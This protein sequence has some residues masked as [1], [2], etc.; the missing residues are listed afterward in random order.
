MLA[1]PS[2][3]PQASAASAARAGEQAAVDVDL[4]A[5]DVARLVAGQHHG[6]GRHFVGQA[7]AAQR[8]V[9][10]QR[11]HRGFALRAAAQHRLPH[12]GQ[13][14]RRVQA[15]AADV[16]ALRRAVQ[17]HRLGVVAH[18]G[19]A[20]RV[21]RR[22]RDADDARAR[23]D[24]DDGAAAAA[25]HRA[26]AVLAAQEHAVEVGAVHGLPVLQAGAFRVVGVARRLQAG[27]AGVVDEHV[28]TA[29]AVQQ[30]RHRAHPGHLLAHVQPHPV[31]AQAR[32]GGA[33]H[34]LVDV[35]DDDARA[36]AHEGGGD[37]LADAARS[38]GHERDLA[39]QSGHGVSP[40][41]G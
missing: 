4:G 41:T 24:V 28:E 22:R 37:G 25:A 3:P 20:R 30:L 16:Q 26:D 35:A 19:L 14:G 17:R 33:A 18:R 36:F 39:G 2:R 40:G 29:V 34:R 11:R 1:Q 9:G 6:H 12:R 15:V 27:D 31:G 23:R 5:G 21:G 38:A 7:E 8:R 32:G 10:H 13:D